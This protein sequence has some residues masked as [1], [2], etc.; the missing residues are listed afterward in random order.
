METSRHI[1]K[2]NDINEEVFP[3]MVAD[4]AR[5]KDAI[6]VKRELRKKEWINN[7]TEL[8]MRRMRQV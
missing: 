3:D 4:F 1:F 8:E 7:Q 6:K 5:R 2:K